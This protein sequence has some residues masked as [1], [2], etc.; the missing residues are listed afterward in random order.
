[1]ELVQIPSNYSTENKSSVDLNSLK[2]V[3]CANPGDESYRNTSLEE[4]ALRTIIAITPT[5][6]RLTQKLD[7]VSLCHT[8]MH[9]P[10]FL[11][12]V[13][14][15]S[16]S[17]TNLVKNVLLRCQVKYVHL[18]AQ[19]TAATKRAGQRGVEQ[20]NTGLA[21]IRKH[22][23]DSCNGHCNGVVYFMDDD[24][25][26]DLRLFHE[27]SIHACMHYSILQVLSSL[28]ILL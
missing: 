12:I 2:P 7:L 22:C 4:S 28:K 10:N 20:R 14:E 19:T 6:K 15:D 27:V 16:G 8:V 23:K 1:M 5:H 13:I 18:H 25:K 21:W 9:I 26:Y 17:K 3:T 11:W 24:N